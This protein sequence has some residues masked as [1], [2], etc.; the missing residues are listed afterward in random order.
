[1]R[2][3]IRIGAPIAVIAVALGTSSAGAQSL[4]SR[5]AAAG[6]GEVRMTY[7]TRANVCG[8]GRNSVAVGDAFTMYPSMESYGHWSNANCVPGRA[9]VSLFVGANGI[10]SVRT[11]V[12]GAWESSSGRVTDLGPVS[13]TAA[14]A[15][16]LDLAEKLDGRMARNT[17]LPA[18]IADSADVSQ[19]LLAI[20]QRTS[21]P[22]ETRR[23]AINW[24]GIFGDASM[25]QPL[26][27][28][29]RTADDEKKSVGEA[30]L[31][32]LSRLPDGVGIPAL[33]DLARSA[34]SLRAR[35]KAVFW[36]GQSGDARGRREVRAIAG[37]A[38]LPDEV[39]EKAVFSLGQSED[40]TAEDFNFL[41]DLFGKVD[42]EKMRDQILMAMSQGED[43]TGRK[44]LLTVARDENQPVEARK[45]A[46]FWAGQTESTPTADIASVYDAVKNQT[47]KVAKGNHHTSSP[48][49]ANGPVFRKNA[50]RAGMNETLTNTCRYAAH[51]G[52]AGRSRLSAKI[53]TASTT[54][55]RMNG[56][57]GVMK[58]IQPRSTRAWVIS[59]FRSGRNA[60]VVQRKAGRKNVMADTTP[61]ASCVPLRK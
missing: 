32:A 15:Y 52:N 61:A 25:V 21:A 33:I 37:D 31:F 48:F 4:A 57:I 36:L 2:R 35:G 9:R 50:S 26:T 12:G 24:L 58:R 53:A 13:S 43:D 41:R 6:Q 54:Y 59:G 51:R 47:V 40:A 45:K 14:A 30:A 8:D 23:R 42:S 20:A 38:R 49:Q 60:A 17:L 22:T 46:I 56:A 44:W 39:R 18:V 55:C 3:C 29:G 5:V 34:P 7:A 27:A 10:E 11:H 1:M 16:F 19:R 28:L